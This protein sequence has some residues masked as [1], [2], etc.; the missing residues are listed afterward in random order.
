MKK[1][2]R[3]LLPL[4][5]VP[6]IGSIGVISL[7]STSG[8]SSLNSQDRTITS[9]NE[10]NYISGEN[11][12]FKNVYKN[13]YFY[14]MTGGTSS[15]AFR[16]DAAPLVE[17]KIKSEHEWDEA[18]QNWTVT[19]NKNPTFP[20]GLDGESA[21]FHNGPTWASNPRFAI[22][23]SK[24]LEIIPNSLVVEIW[25][26]LKDG[27][28]APE[29][30]YTYGQRNM[31]ITQP[32]KLEKSLPTS[33][34]NDEANWSKYSKSSKEASFWNLY[35]SDWD[36]F[37]EA[38]HQ[39]G[40][41]NID[42]NYWNTWKKNQ[43]APIPTQVWDALHS[44][45]QIAALT[46][47]KSY[48]T[49]MR[50]VFLE[51]GRNPG[52]QKDSSWNAIDRQFQDNIHYN[53][54]EIVGIDYDTGNWTSD[55]ISVQNYFVIK[56]QTRKNKKMLVM[57]NQSLTKDNLGNKAYV[58][59]GYS[60]FDH[61]TYVGNW[62]W[63]MVDIDKR[64]QN[65]SVDIKE[66]IA[67]NSPSNDK[68]LPKLNFTV[69]GNKDG[70]SRTIVSTD[71][72]NLKGD[73]I[74]I[75]NENRSSQKSYWSRN[76]SSLYIGDRDTSLEDFNYSKQWWDVRK[77][78]ELSY[79]YIND[80]ENYWDI[81]IEK[82][83]DES[84]DRMTYT[85]N[86]Y[87][88]EL[89]YAKVQAKKYINEKQYL[90]NA[91]K[92]SL[93]QEVERATNESQIDGIKTKADQLDDAQKT[94]IDTFEALKA[95]VKKNKNSKNYKLASDS[96]KNLYDQ[97]YQEAEK[98]TNK[99][100]AEYKDLAK[101]NEL[102]QKIKDIQLDGQSFL[103]SAIEKLNNYQSVLPANLYNQTLNEIN[104]ANTRQEV[105]NALNKIID[106]LQ[107][108]DNMKKA[109]A[110]GK[111]AQKTEVYNSSEQTKKDELNKAIDQIE[112]KIERFS[113]I[114]TL[115]PEQWTQIK[116]SYQ[117]MIDK[118]YDA[119]ANLNGL[120]DALKKEINSYPEELLPNDEKSN[121]IS[122]IDKESQIDTAKMKQYVKE[123]YDKA[124]DN[125]K[126]I[127]DNLNN[128]TE[129]QKQ[130]F[131]NKV[132][133]YKELGNN[134]I[135]D[136]KN[137]VDEAKK[138]NNSQGFDYSKIDNLTHLTDKQKEYW[139][140]QIRSKES[141]GLEAQ[142]VIYQ[143]AV[144]QDSL[145]LDLENAV[146]S[147]NKLK[148]AHDV[149]Y[150]KSSNKAELDTELAKA[151]E[152]LNKQTATYVEDSSIQDS[153]NKLNTLKDNLDGNIQDLK[154][155]I[156]N[157]EVVKL[158]DD[159]Q[160]K[161]VAALIT[162][163]KDSELTNEMLIKADQAIIRDDKLKLTTE[164]VKAKNNG[165]DHESYNQF[166]NTISNLSLDKSQNPWDKE[167]A[168]L[169]AK[170]QEINANLEAIKAKK[171]ELNTKLAGNTWQYLNP[172]QKADFKLQID[173]ASTLEGLNA[174]ES[175]ITK[176][177][178]KMKE[179]KDTIDK[180]DSTLK[181]TNA[182]FTNPETIT[183]TDYTLATQESF[184]TNYVKALQ[185]GHKGLIS[186]E[187]ALD[188]AEI[189]ELIDGIKN[190]TAALDGNE[191]LAAEKTKINTKIDQIP[192]S[193]LSATDKAKL[194]EKVNQATTIANPNSSNE[195][196]NFQST[197]SINNL[198]DKLVQELAK[199]ATNVAEKETVKSGENYQGS[200]Q[201]LKTNYD[202][203]ISQGE[204]ALNNTN[205]S[206][207]D[208][209]DAVLKDLETKNTAISNAKNALNGD[210]QL[211][212][213]K[214]TAQA[215]IDQLKYLND[216]QKQAL[217][218]EIGAAQ[219]SNSV[220]G[221]V[222]KAKELNDAMKELIDAHD[223]HN[224]RAA[225]EA[226]GLEAIGEKRSETPKFKNATNQASYLNSLKEAEKIIQALDKTVVLDPTKVK[227]LATSI[228]T[229]Y[230]NLNGEQN[231]DAYKKKAIDLINNSFNNLNQ[232]QKNS[233][234]AEINNAQNEEGVTN[235][236]VKAKK[237]N[238]QMGILNEEIHKANIR[239]E[240]AEFSN[241]SDASK[242]SFNDELAKIQNQATNNNL[243]AEEIVALIEKTKNL[244]LDGKERLDQKLAELQNKV[245]EAK[246]VQ[247]TDKYNQASTVDKN[248]LNNTISESE[249]KIANPNYSKLTIEDVQKLIEKL[250]KAKNNILADK[251]TLNEE[252]I[253]K[254]E[255]L[256]DQEKQQLIDESRNANGNEAKQEVIDKAK[257]L[258]D[259]KQQIIDKIKE[260]QNSGLNN[261]EANKLIDEVK[262][263]NGLTNPEKLTELDHKIS[264]L[265]DKLREVE[266]DL[267]KL[268]PS[269]TNDKLDEIAHKIEDLK[270]Q[271]VNT[272][273]F[274][275]ALDNFKQMQ[276]FN[277]LLKEFEA[278]DYGSNK[279]E[280]LKTQL[281]QKVAKLKTIDNN[282][283]NN[284]L[285][286]IA[287]TIGDNIDKDLT[288]YE[289]DLELIETIKNNAQSQELLNKIEDA[290]AKHTNR[291]EH[292]INQ[293][294]DDNRYFN[295]VAKIRKNENLNPE[296][297]KILDKV[298]A[299]AKEDNL[300]PVINSLLQKDFDKVKTPEDKKKPFEGL[301]PWWWVILFVATLGLGALG[302]YLYT[303]KKN[304]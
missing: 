178:T 162:A 294:L 12:T 235:V 238:T 201:E 245:N 22:A 221:I 226:K 152:Y 142:K 50:A 244:A 161:D 138:L 99:Q 56:F 304:S 207:N 224:G 81:N 196:T 29:F 154:A 104:S 87:F 42:L 44:W 292:L 159:K 28:G 234:I 108:F 103:D 125:A 203:A 84:L 160:R 45:N 73:K 136:L 3:I 272:D 158:L 90:T 194:K 148:D 86:Y 85:L 205:K 202:N 296:D 254:M 197:D 290:K 134:D 2:K 131:K 173:K 147:I 157:P 88:N 256:N 34:W 76:F 111:E 41:E 190:S 228:E 23:V 14:D 17:T 27:Q 68:N 36:W 231:L 153:I 4:S 51:T 166:K 89:K 268:N 243:Q 222:A 5:L 132:D 102:T 200:A 25:N 128:L 252:E 96:L 70:Q 241:S 293:L 137:L 54:G 300:A 258:N 271:K 279:Y 21:T 62:D 276:S 217:K 188:N 144:T 114:Q 129:D 10:I 179:L 195:G 116:P 13:S 215:E 98:S 143:K 47:N 107:V 101:V 64:Y 38:G 242:G 32:G 46:W 229:N 164:L 119:I 263:T 174:L 18:V 253:K 199:L 236:L 37:R 120:K 150:E 168:D 262:K 298:K 291:F 145:M 124:S 151:S 126:K 214:Q 19:V 280:E 246:E 82:S 295:V 177:D 175:K 169:L 53:V 191:A 92:Q 30:S 284:H 71:S 118:V 281:N 225:D 255:N 66:N 204:Q 302:V 65:Y 15:F 264:D 180:I 106:L 79:K 232:T 206:S 130:E 227:E 303:Q 261:D 97:I 11:K 208:N 112:Y 218:D 167:A 1:S 93:I 77:N 274:T 288:N 117:G 57:N 219:D 172:A 282:Y 127:I 33:F 278:T 183:N 74:Q 210:T 185:D 113:K 275:R 39:K 163:T 140:E 7:T 58:M 257:D 139:K 109:L 100:N 165:L 220:N 60:T 141:E 240:S 80:L 237:E 283:T 35:F 213:K 182:D 20:K 91:Q 297:Q 78:W 67:K 135:T 146:N 247:K 115:T 230:Q 223:K 133:K 110:A 49:P 270:T 285:A 212:A 192:D 250:E 95:D 123:A 26:P 249:E 189:Q 267:N 259:Q 216:A 121:L 31:P 61:N 286:Q 239:K 187:D 43:E 156:Q 6:L 122:R 287:Q 269:S 83:W 211:P 40:E 176:I 251:D 273:Q 266:R 184:K 63:E 181:P 94:L 59:S 186:N 149:S 265:L 170:L 171:A 193:S 52:W 301:S 69:T 16:Y 209:W 233:L 155:K 277:N 9:P 299:S 260:A 72:T 48:N 198:V 105:T 289:L 55:N 248:T 8:T 75:N 24:G